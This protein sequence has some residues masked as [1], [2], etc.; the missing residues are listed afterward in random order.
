ML[1][2]IALFLI[3]EPGDGKGSTPDSTPDLKPEAPVNGDGNLGEQKDSGPGE[4]VP[5]ERVP[6]SRGSGAKEDGPKDN[7]KVDEEREPGETHKLVIVI[8]DV[9]YNLDELKP[10]LQFPGPITFA[11]LPSLAYT[12][13]AL[14]M[15]QK[16]GKEAILHLPMEPEGNDN[17]G[18]GAIF[19]D[20]DDE[21]I[22]RTL[23]KNLDS[24]KGV[25]GAN[26]H[27]G[28]KATSDPR[29]MNIVLSEMKKRKLFFLDSRTS[30]KSV[31]G[32]TANT[33]GLPF[34]ERSVFLDNTQER[35]AIMD[36]VLE[37]MAKAEKSGHAVMIGHVWSHELAEVLLEIYPLALEEGFEFLSVSDLIYGEK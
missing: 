37:G 24:L 35:E 16:A 13:A 14:K 18:P 20:M 15:I 6:G 7:R 19:T 32:E 23:G 11:I 21:T 30:V 26:N 25:G 36:A 29:V 2:V 17:P 33:I 34:G 27:M 8:D 28:S 4:R 3:P 31:V 12:E 10:L 22:K 5:G 1:L 9:G